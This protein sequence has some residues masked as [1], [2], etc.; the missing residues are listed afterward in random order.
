MTV[1]SP[2]RRSINRFDREL[3]QYLLAWAPYGRPPSENC[4]PHFGIPP[5]RF[6]QRVREIVSDYLGCAL[7]A[8]DRRLIAAVRNVIERPNCA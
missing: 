6:E 3:L 2:V 7:N 8:R 4:L 5:H 1:E